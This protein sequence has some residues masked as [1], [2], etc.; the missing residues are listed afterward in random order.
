MYIDNGTGANGRISAIDIKRSIMQL[1][2][3]S[4]GF[5]ENLTVLPVRDRVPVLHL[6]EQSTWICYLLSVIIDI[7]FSSTPIISSPFYGKK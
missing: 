2:T 7:T 5:P 4:R 6:C 3:R 1:V